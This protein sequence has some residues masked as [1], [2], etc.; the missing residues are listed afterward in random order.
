MLKRFVGGN[1]KSN[2]TI[3]QTKDILNN[4]TKFSSSQNLDVV[5][6]PINIHLPLALQL[7]PNNI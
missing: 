3:Q 5:V 2:N 7:K 4:L 6:A 1:W